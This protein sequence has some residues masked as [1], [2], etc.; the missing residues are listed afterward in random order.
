[1]NKEQKNALLTGVLA[2][3]VMLGAG[4]LLTAHHTIR[5]I[6]LIGLLVLAALG[7]MVQ[8]RTSK[9]CPK[10]EPH[11]KDPEKKN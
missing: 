8:G 3:G 4:M 11:T 6:L 7:C 1:M 10:H 2:L 5:S 9:Q